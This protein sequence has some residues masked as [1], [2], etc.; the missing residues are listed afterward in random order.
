[1]N[2]EKLKEQNSVSSTSIK[3]SLIISK[4]VIIKEYEK[5]R[6]EVQTEENCLRD[7]IQKKERKLTDKVEAYCRKVVKEEVKNDSDLN[8]LRLLT[9]KFSKVNYTRSPYIFKN[10]LACFSHASFPYKVTEKMVKKE[11]TSPV[12]SLTVGIH[13]HLATHGSD[14]EDDS[15][16]T[17]GNVNWS[18]EIELP[19]FMEEAQALAD[20]RTKREAL[21]NRYIKVSQ[22][23][24]SIDK[25][26]EELEAR[27]LVRE[28][29]KSEEGKAS[30]G[31]AH[32]LIQETLGTT[33]KLLTIER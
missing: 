33:P 31:L 28:L 18:I 23:L 13:T 11:S 5:E 1:M 3:Q 12:G 27:L 32:E 9:N 20:L 22:D 6:E 16:D 25:V 7:E 30:L 2:L 8:Q 10:N 21:T 29:Q 24:N 19:Q 17:G 4:Q 15:Y 14:L 26:M